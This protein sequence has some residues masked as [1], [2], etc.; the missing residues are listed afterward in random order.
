MADCTVPSPE[1]INGAEAEAGERNDAKWIRL[2]GL[3]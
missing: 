3:F 2:E 1:T